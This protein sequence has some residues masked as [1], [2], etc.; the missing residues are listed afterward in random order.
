MLLNSLIFIY[1]QQVNVQN[2]IQKPKWYEPTAR[3]IKPELKEFRLKI[4]KN[5]MN[6]KYNFQQ[7]YYNHS[8]FQ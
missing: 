5:F 7:Q 3:K 1:R 4:D 2:I 8:D 6:Q